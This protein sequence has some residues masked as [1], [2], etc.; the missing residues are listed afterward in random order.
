M[1]FMIRLLGR[2]FYRC[3]SKTECLLALKALA[4]PRFSHSGEIAVLGI[5][6]LRSTL[7]TEPVLSMQSAVTKIKIS[8]MI[9][10]IL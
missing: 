7:V 6:R 8:R 2:L 10:P 9:S 5:Y 3:F 4:L 1:I